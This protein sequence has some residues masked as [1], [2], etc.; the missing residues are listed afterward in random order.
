MPY[1][2]DNASGSSGSSVVVYEPHPCD[3]CSGGVTFVEAPPSG[4]S[5][6]GDNVVTVVPPAASA[7]KTHVVVAG[8]SKVAA[9]VRSA[10]LVVGALPLLI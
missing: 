1:T 3:H 9:Y 6:G 8:A 10:M 4:P 2:G 5:G 7:T